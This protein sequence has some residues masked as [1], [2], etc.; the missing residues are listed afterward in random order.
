[1]F[2]PNS[3]YRPKNSRRRNRAGF[4]PLTFVANASPVPDLLPLLFPRKSFGLFPA[5]RPFPRIISAFAIS[6]KLVRKFANSRLRFSRATP[7][8]LL[9]R[10]FCLSCSQSHREILFT[11]PVYFRSPQS[12]TQVSRLRSRSMRYQHDPAQAQIQPAGD[13]RELTAGHGVK[14]C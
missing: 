4:R 12:W 3:H 2:R 11:Q 8:H 9:K 6:H 10:L 13:V 7:A 5:A 14:P 1:M